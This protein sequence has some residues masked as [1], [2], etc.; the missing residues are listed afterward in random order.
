MLDHT[1]R[2]EEKALRSS[3]ALG[4]LKLSLSVLAASVLICPGALTSGTARHSQQTIS[5]VTGAQTAPHWIPVFSDNFSGSAGSLPSSANWIVYTGAGFED[6]LAQYTA[7]S[8]NVRLDGQGH[9][10]LIARKVRNGWTSGEVQSKESFEASKG[11]SLLVEARVE[12]PNGGPGYWPAVW[13]VAQSF[14][15]NR[16]SEPAAGEV[17]I[18]ETISDLPWVDQLLHCGFNVSPVGCVIHSTYFH[19]HPFSKPSGEAGWHL[20]AW[21]WV[22]RGSDPYIEM[23]IDGVPQLEIFKSEVTN[24]NWD[25]AFDHPYYLIVNLAIGGWAGDPTSSSKPA[26]AMSVDFVHIFR[27]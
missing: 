22:N 2:T 24:R 1:D 23:F 20:Y 8:P 19:S 21:E 12:L 5:S 17:D 3:H 7:S 11:T 14:R 27:S 13:A 18:A 15:T 9:L 25:A 16:S 26:G 4:W 10:Q 6:E